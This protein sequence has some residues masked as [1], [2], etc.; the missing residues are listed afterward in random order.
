VQTELH[1]AQGR[2]VGQVTQTQ[3]ILGP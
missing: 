1:D 2:L 3:A